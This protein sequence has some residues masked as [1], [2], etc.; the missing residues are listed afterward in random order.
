MTRPP[1]RRILLALAFLLA[2][3]GPTVT[4][5]G[6]LLHPEAAP[7][8]LPITA[9]AA[10]AAWVPLSL[11][12]AG[13]VVA[14][15]LGR[16]AGL[17]GAFAALLLGFAA[18]AQR[19]QLPDG[20][21]LPHGI[22]LPGAALVTYTVATLLRRRDDEAWEAVCGAVGA[23]YTLAAASKLLA[24]GLAWAQGDH[25]ALLLVERAA[26]APGPLAALRTWS[27]GEP[28]LCTS[29][30]TATLILEGA[31]FLLV[32]P[33]LRR[34]LAAILVV[35]HVG[36]FVWLG[37]FAVAWIPVLLAMIVWPRGRS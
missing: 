30:A 23:C 18:H 7:L 14:W 8:G 4:L 9:V 2:W 34:P 29:I 27:A 21:P 37:Y 25:I 10:P 3:A 6:A 22:T 5:R 24:A 11:V 16:R 28:W 19:T 13:A 26:G 17:A 20:L 36:I 33:A 35:L 12:Y 1:P 31:G 15:L 32:W